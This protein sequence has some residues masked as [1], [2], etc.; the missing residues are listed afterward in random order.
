MDTA[1]DIEANRQTIDRGEK[2]TI[3]GLFRNFDATGLKQVISEMF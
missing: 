3:L 1:Y 2:E